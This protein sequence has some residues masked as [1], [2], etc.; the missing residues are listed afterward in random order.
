NGE[1]LSLKRNQVFSK[2][3]ILELIT[4]NGN[5]LFIQLP[6]YI[7]PKT[8]NASGFYIE[9]NMDAVDLFIGSDGSLGIVTEVEIRLLK[10][11]KIIW[12]VTC[13]LSNSENVVAYVDSIRSDLKLISS[14]EYFD[15]SALNIL[16]DQK[17]NNPAF[18]RLP[19]I[20]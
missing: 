16:R 1:S 6:D 18:K 13:F 17:N 3:R 20:N 8:K 19:R 7:M 10:L 14:V 4:D 2:G 12:G 9:D 5:K 11:P 15:E